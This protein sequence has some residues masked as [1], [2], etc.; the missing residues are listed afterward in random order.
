[1]S[2]ESQIE[3]IAKNVSDTYSVLEDLGATM[4]SA[5]T[6]DNLAATAATVDVGSCECSSGTWTAAING[7]T[8]TAQKCTYLRVGGMC[9]ISFE[10]EG[11]GASGTTQGTTTYVKITGLP[12][13]PA[14]G[15]RWY[16][17]GGHAQG[18]GIAYGYY[19]SGYNVQTTDSTLYVRTTSSSGGG[20]YG[21]YANGAKAF[22]MAGSVTY[23]IA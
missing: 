19:F 9:S 14:T 15:A 1:M 18:L 3:R 7:G 17:G 2:V 20:G 10:I 23:P 6:S 11:T 16:G 22:Y 13:T 12:F 8:I 5:R 21:Y 4:P